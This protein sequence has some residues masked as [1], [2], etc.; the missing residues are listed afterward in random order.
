VDIGSYLSG[1]ADGE[2]C[3]SVSFSK[4]QR[5]KFGWEIR[6]SFSISQ[7]GDR[8]EV[9]RLYQKRF[10]CGSIRPD[11]SDRTLKFE[12]RCISDLVNHVIPHFERYPLLS[13]KR[14][15]F[16]RFAKICRKMQ[17]RD[18]LSH[19]GFQEIVRLS[20]KVNAGK[21]KFPREAIKL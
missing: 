20:S 6:P 16:R 18:H 19:T 1:Y 11:R 21:R 3:F 8:A 14:E 7:N 10:G 5:H 9:V 2:G 17:R 12:T 13:R 4:S 15:D